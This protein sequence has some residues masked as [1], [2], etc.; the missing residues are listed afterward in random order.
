MLWVLIPQKCMDAN[1]GEISISAAQKMPIQNRK[2]N[3][4]EEKVYKTMNGTG[5][6]NIVLGVITLVMGVASGVLMIIG[7]AK[8]LYHKSKIMF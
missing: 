7:G 8:L 5:T 1:G 4:M 2:E 6:M 3:Y